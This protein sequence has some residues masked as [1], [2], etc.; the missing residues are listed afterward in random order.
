M[1]EHVFPVL[2]LHYNINPLCINNSASILSFLI[3]TCAKQFHT[4]NIR[5]MVSGEE[6]WTQ[7]MI[8]CGDLAAH[9]S[10]GA[11]RRKTTSDGTHILRKHRDNTHID[12]REEG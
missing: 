3:K 5:A 2:L 4:H 7:I 11:W 8:G 6:F 9:S 1:A 10:L 12:Y